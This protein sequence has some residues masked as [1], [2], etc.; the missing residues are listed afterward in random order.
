MRLPLARIVVLIALATGGVLDAALG[1]GKGKLTGEMALVRSLH[2]RL[3]RGDVVLAD[4]YYSS[5]DEVMTL[6]AMGVDVVMR[7]HGGR[8]V[9]FRR[10]ER[11][12]REDH[13]VA[14]QR[15][16]NRPGWMTREEFAASP[17]V[18]AMRELR[19]RLDKPRPARIAE[20]SGWS[21]A[22]GLGSISSSRSS[23]P[24]R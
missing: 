23:R 17:R 6:A 24:G 20:R 18:L 8:P 5:F 16:R 1:A 13:R 12:G 10:G 15:S 3:K 2:G 22:T 14:W 21:G 4:S 11:L 19:V 9:D 7:E